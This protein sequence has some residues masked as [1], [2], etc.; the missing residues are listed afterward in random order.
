MQGVPLGMCSMECAANSTL[1]A[2]NTNTTTISNCLLCRI[3][4]GNRTRYNTNHGTYC[5]VECCN[6]AKTILVQ[7]QQNP[8]VN[9]SANSTT[10]VL[11]QLIDGTEYIDY[12]YNRNNTPQTR[13]ISS[14]RCI[15]C[16]MCN[17][18]IPL[19]RLG[20]RN[21]YCS[22]GCNIDAERARVINSQAMEGV[23]EAD[24]E[25]DSEELKWSV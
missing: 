5:S 18:P 20:T 16:I 8:E 14:I 15:R 12:L 9:S 1:N 10:E 25:Y 11:N 19:D 23:E 6:R 21:Y 2:L 17:A 24:L 4:L 3:P 22:V 13:P 7:P